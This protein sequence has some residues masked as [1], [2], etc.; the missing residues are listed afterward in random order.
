MQSI[1]GLDTHSIDI[2]IK[3]LISDMDM[4]KYT[5][6]YKTD[7]KWIPTTKKRPIKRKRRGRYC[8]KEH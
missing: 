4:C 7:L 1:I 3:K 2:C 8:D 5:H 6:I